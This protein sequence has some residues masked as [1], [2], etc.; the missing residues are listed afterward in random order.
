MNKEESGREKNGLHNEQGDDA[1]AT[2]TVMCE[3]VT[4]TGSTHL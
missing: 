2:E 3:R 1:A 4:M